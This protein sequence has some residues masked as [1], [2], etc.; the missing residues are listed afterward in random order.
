MSKRNRQDFENHQFINSEEI[1]TNNFNNNN[2]EEKSKKIVKLE[3]EIFSDD[4]CF[5]IISMIDDSWFILNNCTLI[6]KQFFNVIKERSKLAIQFKK[7]FTEK[8]VQL[9][10]KTQFM[11]SI[12]NVTFSSWLLDSFEEAKFITEMKQLISLNIRGYDFGDEE[13]KLISEMKQ[14]TSLDISYNQI[15]DEGAKYLSEM[16]Q[17][18]SL[19]IRG[20]RIGDEGVK[21]ISEMKQLTSLTY[22][23]LY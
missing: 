20:N 7:K 18:I 23:G 15:G 1:F 12:V 4:I 21:Y 8:R 10:L 2:M 11:N 5:E 22:K 6:S 17:L 14:L 3:Q 16:K 9:F 19:N 13:A